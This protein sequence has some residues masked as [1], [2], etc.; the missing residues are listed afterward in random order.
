MA[1][2]MIE[3][4]LKGITMPGLAMRAFLVRSKRDI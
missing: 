1:V 2:F 3:R 4:D